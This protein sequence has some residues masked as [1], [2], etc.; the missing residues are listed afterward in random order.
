MKNVWSIE[1]LLKNADVLR[2][3]K[4]KN[5]TTALYSETTKPEN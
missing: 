1:R 5:P 4:G 2:S 3:E